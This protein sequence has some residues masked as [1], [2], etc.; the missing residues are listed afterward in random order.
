MGAG[1]VRLEALRLAA[2]EVWPAGVVIDA[3]TGRG[4]AI[5]DG[6]LVG[7][8]LDGA[9]DSRMNSIVRY[10]DLRATPQECAAR[11]KGKIEDA[12]TMGAADGKAGCYR[13]PYR[14]QPLE[15]P[16]PWQAYV[17]A[18]LQHAND[19]SE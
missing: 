1:R 17:Q 3:P 12:C 11:Q 9:S 7:W 15:I 5:I 10:E 4:Y 16:N 19:L 8:N 13:N 2:M 14:Y 18:Y 6:C